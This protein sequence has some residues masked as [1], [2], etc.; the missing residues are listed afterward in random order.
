VREYSFISVGVGRR[1]AGLELAED[2]REIIRA[3]AAAG[4]RFVQA[5]SFEQHIDPHIDLVFTRKGETE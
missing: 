4:W 1:R 2:H 3:Q 5:V